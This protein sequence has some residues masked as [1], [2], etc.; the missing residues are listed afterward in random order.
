MM[1]QPKAPVNLVWAFFTRLLNEDMPEISEN[2]MKIND[3][4]KAS[5][6]NQRVTLETANGLE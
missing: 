4:Q 1:R 5:L 6:G 2:F 3:L